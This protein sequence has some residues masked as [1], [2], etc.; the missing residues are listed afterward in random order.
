MKMNDE[1]WKSGD[2]VR[3][4]L[5]GVRGAIPL[6]SRQLDLMARLIQAGAGTVSQFAD[7]GCGDGVLARVILDR[8]PQCHGVLIDFSEPMLEEARR[9]LEPYKARIDFVSADLG[10]AD[11]T[12]AIQARAP[13]DAVVSGYA[14][15][16]QPDDRKRELYG[17]IF[18]LLRPG[19]VFI[20][21]EHVAS[22][23]TW[24]G[25]V[26]DNYFVDALHDFSREQGSAKSREEIAK[27]FYDRPDKEANILAPV[28]TQCE[29]LRALGFQ[30][31]DCYFKIFELAV[32]G[33]R[34]PAP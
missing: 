3:T 4:Y 28:E 1:V 15:H 13:M 29:W 34:R 19:G 5:T 10:T 18:D 25:S 26:W 6:A 24:I 32:F 17:E 16:H 11:W 31:V 2:L 21:V 8:F 33:G 22:A 12:E 7:L 23:S 30:D 9:R 20:N 14:I 27:E